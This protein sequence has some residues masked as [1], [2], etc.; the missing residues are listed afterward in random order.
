V[1][2]RPTLRTYYDGPPEVNASPGWSAMVGIQKT[3]RKRFSDCE[4]VPGMLL[5]SS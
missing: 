2:Q 3:A 4:D 1:R 5:Q